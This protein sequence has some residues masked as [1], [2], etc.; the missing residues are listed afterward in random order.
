MLRPE[1]VAVIQGKRRVSYKDLL[2]RVG[3][4]A[5]VLRN[6]GLARGERVAIVLENTPEYI[7]AYFGALMAGGVA[8]PLG[9]QITERRLATILNDCRP[10]VL[11]APE[12]L[13]ESFAGIPEVRDVKHMVPAERMCEGNGP[14]G[15]PTCAGLSGDDL[16]LLLYTSGTTGEPKGVMLTHR[17]LAA[18]AESIVEYLRLSD[19]D[20]VMVVLPFHYSYGNSLLTTH[21]TAG[22]AVVLENGFVY[23]NVVLDRM[24]EERVTGFAGVPST[25]AILLGRSNLRK[26]TFP[27]LRYVTQ[28]GGAMTPKLARELKGAL[29]GAKIFIM[30]GQTEATARL[31][32]LPSGDLERKAGSI[33][34]PIPGVTLSIHREEGQAAPP[35]EVGE[36]VAR[37]ENVMAG[38]WNDPVGSEQVL[39]GGWLHTG[40]L[41]YVDEDGYFFI[42]GRRSEIIKS[43]AHRISPK[44]IEQAILEMSG[45]LEAAVVGVEDPILGEAI[46]AHVV[47]AGG[48]ALR[49]KSVLL[50]CRSLLPPYMVPKK[51]VIAESLPKTEG[52]KVRKAELKGGGGLNP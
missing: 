45:V 20:T 1:K 40:D 38:Y 51:I 27:S 41:G 23:P 28:A 12:R 33:G 35:L 31:T 9:Q 36:I 7:V 47:P 8:V 48:E 26:R 24:E 42:A 30:Y 52:G 6:A 17:N 22:G 16:A 46:V 4:F 3:A 37:G 44:E 50:H 18:N 11:V 21:V 34:R 29:P 25:F 2:E 15:N 49:E 43:G 14:V 19:S 32:Y 39:R 5:G 13:A 10:A